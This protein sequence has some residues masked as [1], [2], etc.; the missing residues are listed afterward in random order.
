M[1]TIGGRYRLLQEIGEGGF[2][3]VYLAEQ[4]DPVRCRVALKILKLGMDTRQVV[5][6]FE[7]ERQ[8]SSALMDHPGI[9]HNA[10]ATESGHPYFVMPILDS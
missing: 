7:L 6:R 9:A 4:A 8:T 1:N 5:A 3:T 10:G 2:G